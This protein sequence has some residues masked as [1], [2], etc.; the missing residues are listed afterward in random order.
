MICPACRHDN[1][2]RAKFCLECGQRLAAA[3]PQCGTELPPAAKF[4]L[5]CG[6][7]LGA[8]EAAPASSPTVP[9]PGADFQA[10]LASYTPKH[11]AEKILTSRS[12]LEGERRQVTVLFTDV[13]GFTP[14]AEKLDPEDVHR[15]MDRCFE[16]IT[17]EVHRF[18]GTINQ[19]TGDGVMALFGAPIAHED[20]PRRAVHAAL[21]IQRA[22]RDYG[23]E[24]KAQG[25]PELQMRIGI[26]TGLV[27]V[28]RIGDDLRMDY[29]AVG[30][31]TNLAARMQQVARPGS[32]VVTE[33]THRVISSFFETLDLSEVSVKGHAPVRAWEVLRPRLRRSRFEASVERGLTPLVGRVHEVATLLERF[34]EVKAGRG[35]VVF[36]SGDAG[37]GKSRLLL[38]FRRRM[39]EAGEA[40]TWLEGQCIS[41]GQS[42]PFLPLLDQLR[43]NFSIEE[44][45]GEPEIIAKV[46]HGMRRMGQLEAYIPYV[47]YLLSVDPGDP[48]VAAMDA[49]ARRKGVLEAMRAL[50]LRGASIRPI[51]FVF[52][53][54]HW[55]DA[56]T[57]EY[58]N[59]LMGSVAGAPIMVL[60]T[61]RVG[62]NPPF[63]SRSFY[64][65]L[66][67]HTLSEAEAL[68][69]AGLVLGTDQFPVELKAALL[70][71][72]EGVPLFVEEVAKTLLDL[73]VLRRENGGLRM[74]KGVGEVSVPETIHDIIMAR[75]D[76]LG[77][78]GK[79]TVQLASVIGRQFLK[80]LLERIAGL[81]GKLEGLLQEL[82]ALEIIYEQGLL[83]EPAYIFKHAVIQ[84]VAYSSLL[85]E[86]RR[87]LHRAVGG[88]I[89]ELYPDRL[90]DHYQ[91][92][93]HH[94]VSGE[95]WP[96]AFEFLVR[97]GDRAKDAF[98]NQSALDA[99]AKAL[100]ISGRVSPPLAPK[101]IMEIYQRRGQ[102]WR[103]MSRP[104][105][106]IA[107]FN[108]MLAMAREAGDRFAEAQA[109]VDLSLAHYLTFSAEH[110]PQTKA[111]AEEAFRIGREIGDEEAVAKSLCYLGLLYQMEGDLVKG[112]EKLEE[113]LRISEARGF[114]DAIAQN[115]TW[116]G[117][118][119][120]WRAEFHKAI[121]LCRRG[122]ETAREN[123]DGLSELI[124]LAFR[125][126]ALVGLGEHAQGLAVIN[127]GLSLA[128]DRE[129]AWVTGRLT[130]S[131]GWL[132]QELGDFRR[133]TELNR[134]SQ[135]MG[136][137]IKNQNVEVSALINTGYDHLHLD[138]TGKAL[139]VP[140][141]SLVRV[142]KSGFGAHRWRWAMH[143]AT[144]LAETLLALG[145]PEKALLQVEKALVQARAT[146]SLKYVGKAHLLR[147]RIASVAHD[148]TRAEVDLRE[149][150]GIARRIEY[151]NLIWQSAHSLALALAARA[152]GDRVARGKGDD[153][154]AV[155]ALAAD[156][157]HAI[158]ERAPE[159]ALR[160]TFLAWRPV[161]IALENLERLRRI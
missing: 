127:Q 6:H 54:L 92:L 159:A 89:E 86:R 104:A 116:L 18:E 80:R 24:L 68:D 29:T 77:D 88:A 82:K 130:N 149:A 2:E 52:E 61:Y 46:E 27:V 107:E 101:R 117:A 34:T 58:L 96:K 15:I 45:D 36:I 108:R 78:D 51:V 76:R 33:A 93:A 66:A 84:D 158:A 12:A 123:H 114:K 55:I 150:L 160:E 111:F 57:E 138:E 47:R 154:T 63:G 5:E 119:A 43:E 153:A 102:I 50:A 32:V 53:D 14:L 40:V 109:L 142:E 146:S 100:D 112:D 62:Y 152:A 3:C 126:L 37:I 73:G 97:S 132:Y 69:M 140:E 8:A 10:R 118:H 94:F 65:T 17:A 137:R 22:L 83:P 134:E 90:A 105:E 23:E 21:G 103:L 31:T 156:T 49:P 113:S 125:C 98:A 120:H 148:W 16:V 4:C 30:D 144:Y 72:A 145:E 121:P 35:Q 139:A 56:S 133:A 79:R 74:V 157:I 64:T 19:Y 147:G 85:K 20:G 71:K 11:L 106:A 70:D 155:A 26:N 9:P 87:E 59:S 48:A 95:D 60:M 44:F 1:P 124:A 131:L 99:Y 67:L 141:D 42:I 115:L 39:A 161:Q 135:E 128:R 151:P 28:G 129:T 7:Q 110:V 41:F 136:H 25:G 91:E 75:L 81:T 13:A 122:E 38:E 143:L